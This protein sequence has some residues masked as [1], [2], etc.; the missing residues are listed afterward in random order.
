LLARTGAG[1]TRGHRY[2]VCIFPDPA[3]P[4]VPSAVR[5]AD[6]DDPLLAQIDSVKGE[7]ATAL[8]IGK[9]PADV[10][11]RGAVLRTVLPPDPTPAVEFVEVPESETPDR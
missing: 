1:L 9:S 11:L 4:S 5:D 8:L 10:D 3:R 2:F 6:T 7:R